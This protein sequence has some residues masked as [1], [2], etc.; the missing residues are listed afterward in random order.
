MSRHMMRKPWK[1]SELKQRRMKERLQ[2]LLPE[3]DLREKPLNSDLESNVA[4]MKGLFNS[5]SDLVV[6]EF[7][8]GHNKD[9][10]V[11][12]VYIDGLTDKVMISESIMKPLIMH[13]LE[14]GNL[15]L[16]PGNSYDLILN[17]LITFTSL[18]ETDRVGQLLDLILAGFAALF[19]NGYAKAIAL[20]VKGWR[21]RSVEEPKSEA[22]VRGPREA[23]NETLRTNTALI[24]RRI[25]TPRLR[26][27]MLQVGRITKTDVAIAYIDGVV[28]PE[29]VQEVHRRI[30]RIDIDGVLESG[31]LE[32]FIEDNC[33][34]PFALLDRTERPDRVAAMLL[35]GKV[36]IIVDGTPFV[37]VV[38]VV[39]YDFL[40][41][42]EDYYESKDYIRPFRWLALFVSLSLPSFYVA[43]TTFHQEMI[44]TS[45][46]ISMA[47][48]REGVPFPAVVEAL[49]MEITFD[50]LREAGT[51]MPRS[52][53][54]A[55]GVVGALVLGQASVAAGIV[56]PFMVI[57]VALTAVSSFLIP[58]YS[59]SLSL[60][61]LRYPVLLL[62]GAFG[63]VGIFAGLMFILLHLAS[64]RSFGIPYLYPLAPAVYAEMGDVF[65]TPPLWKMD[66]RPMLLRS[67]DPRKQAPEQRPKAPQSDAPEQD[68][69]KG[70]GGGAPA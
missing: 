45:L 12:L 32:A 20:E 16:L 49:L 4:L 29:L 18:K 11:A 62:G 68:I 43:L 69:E 14:S 50:L 3:D 5:T 38:P 59:A 63:L 54:Q 26:F 53:G 23:F 70:E 25:R 41:S 66:H 6:R 30:E 7:H 1:L 13:T 35:E 57:V 52:I 34:T 40:K 22:F 9:V 31:Y 67:P 27:D 17:W 37:L 61:Y 48:G 28:N 51:R 65:Y 44:P 19:I 39:F 55:L 10:Q 46:A 15:E 21:D 33:W 36:A 47:A 2:E 8:F 24:R 64:L 42:Q 60:R 58:N 56:S